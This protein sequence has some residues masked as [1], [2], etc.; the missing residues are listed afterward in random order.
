[1]NG[2]ALEPANTISFA[3]RAQDARTFLLSRGFPLSSFHR[4]IASRFRFREYL[5]R[6]RTGSKG[7]RG[8]ARAT[9][10]QASLAGSVVSRA[11]PDPGWSSGSAGAGV[12]RADFGNALEADPPAATKAMIDYVVLARPLPEILTSRLPFSIPESSKLR[13]VGLVL[14]VLVVS[15]L[16]KFF[17]LAS[18]WQATRATKRV[19]ISMKRQVY[20]HAMRLPLHRVYELKSGGASSSA[21][22]GCRRRR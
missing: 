14:V 15:I 10:G 11:L 18:R 22:R 21:A 7:N 17:G 5:S 9:A 2:A 12:C 1:M 19:Q 16:G 8:P 13:L 6:Y 20:E 4:R 3:G